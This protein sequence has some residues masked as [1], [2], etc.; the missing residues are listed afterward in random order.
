MR[1]TLSTI[2]L[3]QIQFW[4][5]IKQRL[6]LLLLLVFLSIGFYGLYQGFAFKA[7]QNQ[8]IAAFRNE[9]NETL[10]EMVKGFDA[11]T[12]TT[13]GKA[14][15]RKVTALNMVNW[16]TVL[17]AYKIPNTTAIYVIG[18]ADIFPYYYTVK[19]ESFFMQLFK[20]NEIANPLRSLAGHF[21]SS[22][23]IIYLLPL[24]IVVSGFN[25][26]ASELDN[27]NWKLIGSQGVSAKTWVRSKIMLVGL[28]VEVLFLTVFLTGLFINYFYFHQSPALTDLVFF[29][30]A[31]FYLC[32]WLAAIYMINAFALNTSASALYSGVLWIVICIVIPTLV[33]TVTE[34]IV[35]VDNTTVSRMSRRPQDPRL[36]DDVFAVGLIKKFGVLRPAYA[37]AS[38]KPSDPWFGFAKYFVYHELLDDSNHVAV[39][40]YYHNIEYRQRL[41]NA[42][43]VINPAAAVDGIFTHLAHNDAEANHRFVWDVKDFH[44]RMHDALFPPV[45]NVR[46][47]TPT[48][49]AKLPAFNGEPQRPVYTLALINLAVL[50]FMV[51]VL[52]RWA[53]HLLTKARAI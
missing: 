34:K 39:A 18:Q 27:G 2:Q 8:I 22:F 26:L 12:L 17:P 5:F 46:D 29:V 3:V 21:D 11:D 48:D 41:N 14:A 40:T 43:V 36:E 28:C 19:L 37:S 35:P 44:Q 49:F 6:S 1:N 15:Y 47:F 42:S 31:N 33:T 25:A 51:A 38:I 9:K 32:F 45:F 16:N 30:L 52:M 24:L 53:N 20:Q 23:W 10:R 13:E 4:L 50:L 7:K